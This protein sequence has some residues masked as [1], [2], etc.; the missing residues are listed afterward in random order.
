MPCDKSKK[1]CPKCGKT[2]SKSCKLKSCGN[3]R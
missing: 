3:K 1:K 2:S